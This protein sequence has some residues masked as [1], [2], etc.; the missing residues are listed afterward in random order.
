MEL[1]IC[2]LIGDYILQNTWMSTNKTKNSILGYFSCFVHAM[3]YI[4]PFIFIT[5]N[6]ISLLIICLSH[7]IIDK[8]RVAILFNKLKNNITD[9]TNFGFSKDLPFALSIWLAIITDNTF[10]L[11]IN[12]YSILFFK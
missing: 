2:H 10:H 4:L 6:I 9:N 12:Y 7:F 11:I 1:L 5:K 3:L 8:Y